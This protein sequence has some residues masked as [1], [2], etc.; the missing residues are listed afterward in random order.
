MTFGGPAAWAKRVSSC[1]A[2]EG[3]ASVQRV[4][5]LNATSSERAVFVTTWGTLSVD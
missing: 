3:A 2:G 4:G 1:R 5:P